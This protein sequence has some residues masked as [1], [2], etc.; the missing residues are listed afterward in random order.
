MTQPWISASTAETETRVR[1]FINSVY[2]WMFG[3][4]LLTAFASAW[5]ITSPA[6]QQLIFG[7]RF[8]IFGLIIVELGLVFAMSA[9]LR[10]FSPA[11]AASMFLV[12]SLLNGLTLSVVLLAYTQSSV[13]QAFITA[14]GMFGAMSV[15]GM[16]THTDL[17]R[18]G[19]ILFMALIGLVIA[20]VVNMFWANSALYWIIT[21]AGVLIFVGLT[22]Y[23][24]QKLKYIATATANDP[25]AAARLSVNG[26]LSLYLDF[27]NLFLMLLRIMGGNRRG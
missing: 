3:G 19:S 25:R 15:Y 21:Y 23:D 16:L 6:M 18:M 2:A 5:V 7:N 11:T 1:S 17:S 22:A 13:V 4:L 26:A 24:T 27:L 20:S 12:Y 8:M 9:G 10:R 14:A